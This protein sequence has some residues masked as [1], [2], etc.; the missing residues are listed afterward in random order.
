MIELRNLLARFLFD[1]TKQII[2]TNLMNNNCS[3]Y[4]IECG[5][6][7]TVMKVQITATQSLDRETNTKTATI[8]HSVL[9]S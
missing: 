5:R 2:P 3:K 8:E 9:L 4:F 7:R 6:R 1:K